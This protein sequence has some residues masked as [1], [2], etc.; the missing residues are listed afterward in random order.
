MTSNRLIS[1]MGVCDGSQRATMLLQIE[2]ALTRR[3]CAGTLHGFKDNLRLLNFASSC[4]SEWPVSF[5]PC[6]RSCFG[7]QHVAQ[8]CHLH[9]WDSFERS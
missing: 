9:C 1:G 4:R 7:Y 6:L 2:S 8:D 5:T 3:D